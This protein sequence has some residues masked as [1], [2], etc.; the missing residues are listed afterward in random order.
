MAG[1][2]LTQTR[3]RS[4]FWEGNLTGVDVAPPLEVRHLEQVLPGMTVTEV[5]G[6]AGNWLVRV[7]IPPEVLSEGVQ[8]FIIREQGKDETLA[9]FTV[10]TGVALEDDLRAEID[11][12]RAELDLLK[13]AF[14]RHCVETMG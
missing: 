13:R 3:I 4:G 11:L 8:T 10:V 2:Q 6:R 9:H 12:L 7:P 14:R 1:P 5:P